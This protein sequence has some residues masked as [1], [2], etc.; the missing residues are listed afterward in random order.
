MSAPE[1][2][3]A[4]PRPRFSIGRARGAAQELPFPC[5]RRPLQTPKRELTGAGTGADSTDKIDSRQETGAQVDQTDT[6][7][8]HGVSSQ[9]RRDARM[10]AI[11][12]RPWS[13]DVS[14]QELDH[15]PAPRNLQLRADAAE[16]RAGRSRPAP[17]SEPH[18]SPPASAQD[19]DGPVEARS[20]YITRGL[21]RDRRPAPGRPRSGRVAQAARRTRPR[22][23]RPTRTADTTKREAGTGNPTTEGHRGGSTN[24][25]V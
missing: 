10:R 18:R 7:E 14:L 24:D 21:I 15:Q 17:A 12:R 1:A 13:W 5:E 22:A 2:E 20:A 11:R 25:E 3:T 19:V 8:E 9:A 16:E 6:G 23:Q 4:A